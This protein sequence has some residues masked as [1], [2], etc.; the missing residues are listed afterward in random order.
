V[1]SGPSIPPETPDGPNASH[2]RETSF[3]SGDE[4]EFNAAT[5]EESTAGSL[6]S[7]IPDAPDDEPATGL[8]GENDDEDDDIESFQAWLRGLKR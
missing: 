2:I 7:L 1:P 5:D 8:N 4:V 6:E 3:D